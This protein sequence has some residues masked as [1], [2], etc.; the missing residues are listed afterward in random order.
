MISDLQ[1]RRDELLAWAQSCLD[2]RDF[3]GLRDC[4][5]DIEV[6]E[7]R[8]E[9]RAK[10]DEAPNHPE[11]PERLDSRFGPIWAN[12]RCA[13]CKAVDA[14]ARAEYRRDHPNAFKD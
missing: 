4:A 3:H 14:A 13:S 7:A 8:L 10:I 1:K 9:E 12:C 2:A 11:G 6:I 5:C